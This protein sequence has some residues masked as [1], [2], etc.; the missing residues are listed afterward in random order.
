MLATAGGSAAR[1]G[2]TGSEPT[3]QKD[4]STTDATSSSACAVRAKR[5]FLRVMEYSLTDP[6]GIDTHLA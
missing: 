1:A 3:T 6:G 4:D 2:P 5:R